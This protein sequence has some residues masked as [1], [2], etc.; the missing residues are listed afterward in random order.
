MKGDPQRVVFGGYDKVA[1][2]YLGR[3]GA[4]A[5]RQR[6][7]ERLVAG[8][9]RS[10]GRVVDL[11]C[12]AGVPVARDLTELGHAVIGVDGSSQQIARARRNVPRAE[13]IEADM[14]SV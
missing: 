5:V 10:G 9:P 14:C 11:G 13:F 2:I 6:W 8:L 4:S 12:G 3:F 7:F 1:D